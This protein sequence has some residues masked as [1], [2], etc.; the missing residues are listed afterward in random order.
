MIQKSVLICSA[1][2]IVGVA[3]VRSEK[4]NIVLIMCDDM[5]YSDLGCYGGE[6]DTP[7]ID[8]LAGGGIR[9]SHF[10]NTGR[11]CPSRA[12]L[13]T[14]RH[15][16][17]VGL[18]WMT[19]VDEHRPGYRG[20]IAKEIPALAEIMK[21]NGYTTYMAGKWHLTVDGA[22][23]PK[24]STPNGSYPTQRGFDGYYGSLSGAGN[25]YSPKALYLSLIHI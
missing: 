24:D 4:P 12:S 13:L 5:G 22:W 1:L 21:E 19:A 2:L 11:C 16:H 17:A 23:K 7:N 15:Q 20:Q 3:I 14:G 18:G 8:A 10:K 9:F 6:I 25:F